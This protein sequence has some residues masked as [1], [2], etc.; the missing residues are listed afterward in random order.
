MR[1]SFTLPLEPFSVNRTYYRDR[2]HKT[3]DFRDWELATINALAAPA[4][5][6][7]LSQIRGAFDAKKHG[8]VVRF[9]AM[10]PASVLFNK[11]GQ[12]SSRAEDLSNIEKPL[13]DVLFLPKYHVQSFPW[14]CPN[15][16]ADDKYVLRLTSQKALSP[17]DNHYIQI[18]IGIVDLPTPAARP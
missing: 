4:V 3:Q 11:Q 12:I 14:G 8:F 7:K 16:N 15:V 2:R 13:L 1:V 9:K 18:S 10:Y 5:Q 17:N 6:T